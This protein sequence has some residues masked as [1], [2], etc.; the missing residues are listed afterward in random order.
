MNEREIKTMKNKK[1]FSL[2]F[3]VIA[4]VTLATAGVTFAYLSATTATVTN[5][6]TV[7][8]VSITLAET[9]LCT[10]RRTCTCSRRNF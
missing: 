5:T 2:I 3:S 1:R 4:L 8:N 6:F 7:G 10:C 9:K